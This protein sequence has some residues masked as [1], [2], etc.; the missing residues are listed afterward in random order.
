MNYGSLFK[1]FFLTFTFLLFFFISIFH[2]FF[3]FLFP[4]PP[5]TLLF[6]FLF[7]A[8]PFISFSRIVFNA[9]ENEGGEGKKREYFSLEENN[10]QVEGNYF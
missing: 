3:I 5:H 9:I 7:F 2:L 1:L 6:L 10:V 4:S 8:L